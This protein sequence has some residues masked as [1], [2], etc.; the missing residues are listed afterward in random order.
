MFK[1]KSKIISLHINEDVC[2]GCG[3]CVIRCRRNVLT[4]MCDKDRYLA[5]VVDPD[6]CKGCG[7]CQVVCKQDAIIISKQ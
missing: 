5:V 4:L 3:N 2:T 6:H 1:W 7:H